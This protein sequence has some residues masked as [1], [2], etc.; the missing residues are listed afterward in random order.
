[1]AATKKPKKTKTTD[2]HLAYDA[3]TGIIGIVEAK[4]D[5]DGNG[6][7]PVAGIKNVS[8]EFVNIN[9]MITANS[10]PFEVHSLG[11]STSDSNASVFYIRTDKTV[12]LKDIEKVLK[13][14]IES[15]KPAP[16]TTEAEG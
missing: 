6:V 16:I 8:D 15:V 9:L 13:E 12:D 3:S 1:M 5:K 11:G 2:M 4:L 14:Y 10:T 7:V